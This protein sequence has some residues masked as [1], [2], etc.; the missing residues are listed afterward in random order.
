[1]PEAPPPR[2]LAYTVDGQTFETEMPIISVALLRAKLP[3]EKRSFGI[4]AEGVGNAPD[5]WLD[6]GAKILLEEGKTWRFY[7]SPPAMFG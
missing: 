1:M 6:E 5:R 2:R 3:L 7:T 4:I